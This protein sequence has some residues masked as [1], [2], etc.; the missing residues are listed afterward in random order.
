MLN[1]RFLPAKSNPVDCYLRHG[2]TLYPVTHRFIQVGPDQYFSVGAPINEVLADKESVSIIAELKQPLVQGRYVVVMQEREQIFDL[3]LT[4]AELEEVARLRE[5]RELAALCTLEPKDHGWFYMMTVPLLKQVTLYEVRVR[6]IKQLAGDNGVS[7]TDQELMWPTYRADVLRCSGQMSC[8]VDHQVYSEG[9]DQEVLFRS[10][11]IVTVIPQ[12]ALASGEFGRP[13]FDS[14]YDYSLVLQIARSH[15]YQ[16]SINGHAMQ[17]YEVSP[18]CYQKLERFIESAVVS[19]TFE[20]SLLLTGCRK[21]SSVQLLGDFV[22]FILSHSAEINS[23]LPS[24]VTAPATIEVLGVDNV[25]HIVA[26]C[27]RS[28]A[29]KQKRNVLGDILNVVINLPSHTD[30]FAMQQL[31]RMLCGFNY[32]H[33]MARFML[34]NDESQL[35]K[36]VLRRLDW[37]V[38]GLP[39][40]LADVNLGRVSAIAY[41]ADV[42][43]LVVSQ[44]GK[45]SEL[46][47]QLAVCNVPALNYLVK[48]I[49]ENFRTMS[50]DKPLAY[51]ISSAIRQVTSAL[52]HHINSQHARVKMFQDK[53]GPS[54]PQELFAQDVYHVKAVCGKR[55]SP[56]TSGL[57]LSA[58]VFSPCGRAAFGQ[59]SSADASPY[60]SSAP[61]INR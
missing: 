34:Q 5:V 19:K 13:V 35:K 56:K 26:A 6:K 49:N 8:V 18:D 33:G 54:G 32:L 38:A 21:E 58:T 44:L 27:L 25:A 59:R 20:E 55:E 51:D 2:D 60:K 57:I 42:T 3:A 52:N 24:F 43:E 10:D 48:I 46:L 50:C 28:G 36:W 40:Y 53:G 47:K 17:L 1:S 4:N 11:K 16:A 9:S 23:N 22:S 61:P 14:A 15:A 30:F 45:L 7:Y 31:G 39:A 12:D 41:G 37:L 29:A